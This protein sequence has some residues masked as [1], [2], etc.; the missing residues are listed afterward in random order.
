M[1]LA[2]RPRPVTS[3]HS[4]Y[5]RPTNFILPPVILILFVTGDVPG[6]RVRARKKKRDLWEG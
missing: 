6:T 3:G 2:K 5:C 1:L 4:P